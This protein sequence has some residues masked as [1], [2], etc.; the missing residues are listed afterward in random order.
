M[1]FNFNHSKKMALEKKNDKSS[2]GNWDNK[3]IELC[4]KINKNPNYYTTSSCSGRIALIKDREKKAPGA[5][6]FRTHNKIDFKELKKELEKAKNKY[7]KLIYFKQEPCLVVVACKDLEKQQE[8]LN[9]ARNAGLEKSGI[10]TIKTKRIVEIISTE[11]INFPIINQ[12]QILAGEDFLKLIVKESNKNLEKT[13]DK[14]KRFE[15]LI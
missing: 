3:I 1:T 10:I 7:N 9:K 15:K 2:I 5:F 11:K 4:K 6:L 8:I 13:W 12:E 14:I